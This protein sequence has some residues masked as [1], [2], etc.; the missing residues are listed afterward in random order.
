MLVAAL[1]GVDI[2]STIDMD[3]TIKSF[4]VDRESIEAV[5]N[6]ILG[7][8]IEDGVEMTLKRVDEI[9]DK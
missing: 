6:M 2:R 4:P 5:F 7:L 9:R 3:A 1:V 8:P